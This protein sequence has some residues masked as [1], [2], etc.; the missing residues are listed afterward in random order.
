M[1]LKI[2]SGSFR[3][4]AGEA[5]SVVQLDLD[6]SPVKPVSEN[7]YSSAAVELVPITVTV[8]TALRVTGL[9]RTKLYELIAAGQVETVKVGRRRLVHLQSLEKLVTVGAT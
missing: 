4:R 7:G 9:G 1:K 3:H 2:A 5:Q 6:F 8:T